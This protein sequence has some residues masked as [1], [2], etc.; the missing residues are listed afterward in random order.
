MVCQKRC[1]GTDGIWQTLFT[2]FKMNAR[3]SG[4]SGDTLFQPK[5][6]E[7]E[8]SIPLQEQLDYLSQIPNSP[9]WLWSLQKDPSLQQVKFEQKL[10]CSYGITPSSPRNRII[11]AIATDTGDFRVVERAVHTVLKIYDDGEGVKEH[12]AAKRRK[13]AEKRARKPLDIGLI[14]QSFGVTQEEA[15]VLSQNLSRDLTKTKDDGL[16]YRYYA[17]KLLT[18]GCM[19]WRVKTETFQS[20]VMNDYDSDSGEFK[21]SD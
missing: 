11:R 9:K 2:Q 1:T 15:V 19:N 20:V 7:I 13:L 14:C 12:R 10:T 8:E 17:E 18:V 5:N 21:V 16:L 6:V 4:A 3:A